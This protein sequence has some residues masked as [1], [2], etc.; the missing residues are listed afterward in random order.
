MSEVKVE[1][2]ERSYRIFVGA[3]LLDIAASLL[4]DTVRNSVVLI[5]DE[6][7]D[8]LYGERAAA[9]LAPLGQVHRLRVTPGEGA[10]SLTTA[11]ELLTRMAVLKVR[12][13]DLV[14]T[15]GGG[16]VSDL[17]GFVASVYQRGIAFAHIPTSLLGQVD[18][19]IGGKTGVNLQAGKNL[20]GTFAQPQAVICDVSLLKSLP[21]RQF[22]SGLA[23]VIKYGLCYERAILEAVSGRAEQIEAQDPQLL[24]DLVLRSARIKAQVVSLDETDSGARTMLNYGHTFGHALEAAG[25]YE[26]WLHGEAIALGM[27]FVAHLAQAM[28]LLTEDEVALHRAAFQAVGLPVE[29]QFD[30]EVVADAWSIDKK[31]LNGQ[32]WVLLEGIGRPAVRTD[33]TSED[34]QQA[35]GKVLTAT[36][37][38]GVRP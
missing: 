26:T 9:A 6:T 7:V 1:L 24:E 14:V 12:R 31:F 19:A 20:A 11:G 30:P 34:L 29:A 23:E 36:P 18:A 37:L 33:V 17:G 2:G 38:G 28:D 10:K 22:R 8:Q 4:P 35:M 25:G 5:V 15:L 13:Q 21:A 16:V 27:M 32:R 3:G